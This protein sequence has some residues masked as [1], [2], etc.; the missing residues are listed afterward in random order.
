MRIT[1]LHNPKAGRGKLAKRDLTAA[2]AKAGHHA[3]Y[4][5]TRNSDYKK[6]LKEPTDLVL[7]AGGDG[8]VGK[9]GHELIDTG[10]PLAVLPLGTANNLARSLGFCVSPEEIITGLESA[11]RR[12][13]DVGLARGPWGKRYFF[14]GA[15]GGL[16]ADYLRNAEDKVKR[17]ENLSKDEEMR[18]H[19]SLLRRMLHDYPA[20]KWKIALDGEDIS[21]RYILWEAMNIR[22]VGPI[23]YFASHA[24]TK[25]GRLDFVCV[26]EE[27]RSL[28]RGYLDG[29]L[30]GRKAKFPLSLRRFRESKILWENST[31]HFDDKVWPDKK[32][33]VKN[34]SDIEITVKPSALVILQPAHAKNKSA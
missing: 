20:R 16:L 32:Q 18:R 10:I 19:V 25:D 15:G 2:L 11:E 30:A 33:K 28:F 12:T 27:D 6:A 24:A 34:P 4:Q 23:L 1:L 13:F 22:S 29:R 14:E 21:N 9:V 8:T 17:T 7:A 26:Q 3:I 5:S 31:L